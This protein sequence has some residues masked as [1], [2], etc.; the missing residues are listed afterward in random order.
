MINHNTFLT[1]NKT[2]RVGMFSDAL[3]KLML[4]RYNDGSFPKGKFSKIE[5]LV[6]TDDD[7]KITHIEAKFLE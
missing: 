6:Y 3:T 7:G 5:F 2:E 1:I 4:D